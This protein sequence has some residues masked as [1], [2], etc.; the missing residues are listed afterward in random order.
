MD[1]QAP[2][3][4]KLK[5]KRLPHRSGSVSTTRLIDADDE[6]QRKPWK[7]ENERQKTPEGVLNLTKGMGELPLE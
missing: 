2:R 4:M 3:M 7:E 1:A 5:L 6:E